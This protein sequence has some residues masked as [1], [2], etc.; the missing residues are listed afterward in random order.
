MIIG[1][2]DDMIEMGAKLRFVLQLAVTTATIISGVGFEK[3]GWLNYPLTFFW[4]IG[5]I[6]AVN[7]IDGLDG[8]AAG[9]A[10]TAC[11]G[12]GILGFLFNIPALIVIACILGAGCLGFL[13]FNIHPAKIFMGD[14][15]S[16][17][18]GYILAVAAF[19][20]KFIEVERETVE[21]FYGTDVPM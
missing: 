1:I 19:I 7:L 12:F 3:W 2:I 13:V 16:V 21:S 15:G 17:P 11:A 18:L 5:M 20:L 6:N 9:I 4:F 10:I 14:T 8:L